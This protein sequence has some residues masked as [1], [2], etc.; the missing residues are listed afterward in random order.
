MDYLIALVNVLIGIMIWFVLLW[1]YRLIF[2][3][4]RYDKYRAFIKSKEWKAKARAIKKKYDNKCAMCNEGWRLEVHHMQYTDD[5]LNDLHLIC[6]CPRCHHKLH[7]VFD[8]NNKVW[9]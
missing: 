3:K 7:G 5:L 2:R 1:L 9:K 6:L 4:S 8:F